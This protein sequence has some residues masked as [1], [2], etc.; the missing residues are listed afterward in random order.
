MVPWRIEPCTLA[1]V[2]A[3]ARNNMSA[4]WTDPNWI[5]LWPKDIRLDFLIEQV[6]E[7]MPNSLLGNRATLRHQKAVDPET[8]AVVGYARW[9]LPAGYEGA[10]AWADSQIADVSEEQRKTFKERSDAAWWKPRLMNGIDDCVPEKDRVLAEKP[11]ISE[12]PSSVGETGLDTHLIAFHG[13]GPPFGDPKGR[14]L[15]PGTGLDYLAVHP[16]NKGKGV[17]TALVENGVRLAEETGVD[18]FILAFPAGLNVYKRL[19]FKEIHRGYQDD[20]KYGG[21]GYWVTLLTYEVSK[22]SS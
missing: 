22:T 11:Y 8:G 13:P 3:L 4:F 1:D 21:E 6:T 9:E 7:R 15:T 19:G 18:V 5:L 2:P 17:A 12:W 20:I 10:A 14:R 16:E